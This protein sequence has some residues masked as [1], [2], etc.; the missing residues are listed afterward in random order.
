M[1][2]ERWVASSRLQRKRLSQLSA[3]MWWHWLIILITLIWHRLTWLRFRWIFSSHEI[4]STVNNGIRWLRITV[5][6][7]IEIIYLLFLDDWTEN[8]LE[9]WWFPVSPLWWV[10]RTFVSFSV[11]PK[12]FQCN[13][14]CL[15]GAKMNTTGV[16]LSLICRFEIN[17][18]VV[19]VP[20]HTCTPF[21]PR[22]QVL[23]RPGDPGGPIII[24]RGKERSS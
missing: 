12:Y 3:G 14:S 16:S 24:N 5:Y 11:N 13:R 8:K 7:L 21:Y 2:R 19:S 15:S 20:F 23:I 4:F 10:L 22:L 17:F 9:E 6:N 1:S 18:K